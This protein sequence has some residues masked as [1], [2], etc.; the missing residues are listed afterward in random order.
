ML[1]YMTIVVVIIYDLIYAVVEKDTL[2]DD[3]TR[4]IED[5]T[6]VI[7]HQIDTIKKQIDVLEQNRK[8]DPKESY[9]LQRNKHVQTHSET[10]MHSLTTRL[11]DI[12]KQFASALSKRTQVN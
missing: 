5:L 9:I 6:V 11:V 4:Q 2:F 1:I 3:P 7:K 10:V 8:S 12:T